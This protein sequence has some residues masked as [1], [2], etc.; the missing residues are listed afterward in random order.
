MALKILSAEW[1][2]H[3]DLLSR[4]EQE[5]RLASSLNHPN[6][7]TIH[8]IGREPLPYIAMELVEGETL[9]SLIQSGGLTVSRAVA[10][11]TQ[12]AAGLAK[13][14]EAGIIHRDLKPQN[15]MVNSD[16]V[17]KILDF[18]ISKRVAAFSESATTVEGGFTKSGAVL[19]TAAYMSPEQASARPVDFRSDQ[20]A[21][22]AVLYE[23]LTGH[24]PFKR[25]TVAQT[26][27]AVIE[28]T[29]KPVSELNPRVPIKV[30]QIVQR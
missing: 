19:G 14:H 4:F 17:V 21:F 25:A 8:S 12:I 22:G 18:G 28:A 13:A 16:G 6:I 30:E 2:A 9:A 11:A 24:A 27:S 26:M 29:P 7:V 20:F 23:M 10:I 1:R 5:A 15:I 3:P